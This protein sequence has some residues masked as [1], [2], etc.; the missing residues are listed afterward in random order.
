MLRITLR[1]ANRRMSR[2]LLVKPPDL[3]T[4]WVKRL[5]V[6]VVT[7]RPVSARPLRNRWMM[8]SRVAS[9]LPKGI[10]SSSWKLTP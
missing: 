3:K 1:I 7:T 9:S 4:G 8:A 2:S 10:T 6:A 5:V